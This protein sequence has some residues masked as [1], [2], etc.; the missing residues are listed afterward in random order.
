MTRRLQSTVLV[1]AAALAGA[2]V[3]DDIGQIK[4]A[5]GAVNVE[6]GGTTQQAAVGMRLQTADT[7]RT[8]AD[9]SVGITMNDDSL[10]SAGPNSVLVLERYTLDPATSE[11]RFDTALNKGT[12]VV[13]SGRIAK[14][15]PDAMT[16]RTPTAILGA[17][18]TEFAV[19]VGE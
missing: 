19:S 7:L 6:R 17:R 1:L 2:A 16:V 18:G 5:R 8:G 14:Q 4:V 12:L 10:L 9:G 13:V 11:G 15:A 3:A